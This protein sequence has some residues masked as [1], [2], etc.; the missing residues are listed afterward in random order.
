MLETDTT[1]ITNR[2]NKSF[3]LLEFVLLCI[4]E[5]LK[6]HTSLFSRPS[7]GEVCRK[8]CTFCA[9]V[10]LGTL[11]VYFSVVKG[12]RKISSKE[13]EFLVWLNNV[14]RQTSLNTIEES[15]FPQATRTKS[16]VILVL[17]LK[18]QKIQRSR[19]HQKQNTDRICILDGPMTMSEL[20]PPKTKQPVPKI[21]ARNWLFPHN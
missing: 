14:R 11:L 19:F 13:K 7:E 6:F 5:G 2:H 20:L 1:S 8:H 17:S 3:G 21:R 4:I 18:R 16:Q 12:K 10:M 15:I 9:Y